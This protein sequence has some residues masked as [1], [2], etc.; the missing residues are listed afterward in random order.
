MAEG[1]HICDWVEMEMMSRIRSRSA[2][3]LASL[4]VRCLRSTDEPKVRE[5]ISSVP[6]ANT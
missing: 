6:V 4:N 1:L 5:S 3:H 2:A